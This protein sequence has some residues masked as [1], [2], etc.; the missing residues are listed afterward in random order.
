MLFPHESKAFK[1]SVEFGELRVYDGKADQ[2]CATL[3][4]AKF[5][6]APNPKTMTNLLQVV[7]G[8]VVLLASD[9]AEMKATRKVIENV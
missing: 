9:I 6:D 8:V 4:T 3:Q 7:D 2:R 1:Q 5:L